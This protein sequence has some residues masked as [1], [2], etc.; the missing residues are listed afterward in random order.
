MGMIR[1]SKLLLSVVA[2][3][4]F[5][6]GAA[7][8]PGPIPPQAIPPNATVARLPSQFEADVVNP[9]YYNPDGNPVDITGITDAQPTINAAIIQACAATPQSKTVIIPP[10]KYLINEATTLP[11]N[12]SHLTIK[13]NDPTST[14][15]QVGPT[16]MAFFQVF[17]WGIGNDYIRI[18]D[19]IFDGGVGTTGG[20]N[21]GKTGFIEV[22]AGARDPQFV[23]NTFRHDTGNGLWIVGGAFNSTPGLAANANFGDTT[24][25]VAGTIPATV[26]VGAYFEPSFEDPDYYIQSI[27]RVANTIT[28]QKP[29]TDFMFAGSVLPFTSA[30]VLNAA[31]NVNDTTMF[32]SDTS[33]LAIGQVIYAGAA[34]AHLCIIPGTRITS[35]VTN[36]SVAI[37]HALICK[38][39]S[40][41]GIGAELG[42]TNLLV[43]DNTFDDLGQTRANATT[44]SYTTAASVSSGNTVLFNCGSGRGCY[45]VG[46]IDGQFT[47]PTTGVAGMPGN[48]LILSQSNLNPTTGTFSLTFQNPVTSNIPAGTSIPFTAGENAGVG[49][50]VWDA[51]GIFWSNPNHK[52]IHNYA[53]HTWSSPLFVGQTLDTVIADNVFQ[54]DRL[55]FQDPTVPPSGCGSINSTVGILYTGNVCTG[56]TGDGNDFLH[57]INGIVSNN[58]WY[59]TG[60]TALNMLGGRNMQFLGNTIQRAGQNANYA[61]TELQP[62]IGNGY[63]GMYIGG[64]W[65]S[66]R[67]GQATGIV[68]DDLSSTDDALVPTQTYGIALNNHNS[69][70]LLTVYGQLYF[71]GNTIAP[72]DPVLNITPLAPGVDNR[73]VNPCG[74]I[75][76][77]N[78]GAQASLNSYGPDE[79]KTI[80][81]PAAI[82][83]QQSATAQNGCSNSIKMTTFNSTASPGSTDIAWLSQPY[84]AGNLTDLKYGSALASNVIVDFCAKTS[85]AGTYGWGLQSHFPAPNLRTYASSYTTTGTTSQC[86]SFSVPG[87]T[88]TALTPVPTAEGLSLSFDAGSGSAAYT[89][90]CNAWQTIAGGTPSINQFCNTSGPTGTLLTQTNGSTIEISAVRFYPATVDV[91][92][93]GTSAAQS[94]YTVYRYY[95]KTF[96]IGTVPAQNA[97]LTGALCAPYSQMALLPV[98]GID[99]AYPQT[100]RAIPTVTSY[101]PSA[102]NANYRDTTAAGDVTATVNADGL[103][104]PTQTLI[105]AATAPSLD[106]LCIQVVASARY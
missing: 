71:N 75:D 20:T 2:L 101:N 96:P 28:F 34:A 95:S 4:S 41:M 13:A 44:H 69:S 38:V 94:P 64:S 73:T 65:T 12:C 15:L 6:I 91:A 21:T 86:F 89:S 88:V 49:Y 61:Q 70:V 55:E 68:I 1:A 7:A 32:T 103:A 53:R 77:A 97:G 92:W 42:I 99:W 30:F 67:I 85:T 56:T 81:N 18:Q 17:V 11:A 8:Q 98:P 72:S 37:D 48:N 82:H 31:A 40:G 3:V 80:T 84:E 23:G 83:Y 50:A 60:L 5:A 79:W 106:V 57:S 45:M 51:F 102:A 63:A 39:A 100:M 105:G 33:G 26:K 59:D 27:D 90:T 29:L 10:G 25:T 66:A 36:T 62:A 54:I 19:L 104:D 43:Q 9:L 93:V 24:V 78:A 74:S 22:N 14:V 35:F 16:N 47:M 52:F 76:Q 46:P 58:H 87:D